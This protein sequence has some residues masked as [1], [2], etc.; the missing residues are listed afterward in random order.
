MLTLAAA[1]AVGMVGAACGTGDD[2]ATVPTARPQAEVTPSPTETAQTPEA[3]TP[4]PTD[5]LAGASTEAAAGPATSN[6]PALLTAVRAARQDGFDRVVFE[7][8]N[9]T[10]GYR[11]EYVDRPITADGSGAAL[12]VDGDA[13]LQ[14]RLANASGVDLSQPDAPATYAG[15]ARIV[16]ATS[17]VAEI[18]RAG[19]FEGMLTW[20]VGVRERAAFRT[21]TLSDPPRLVIDVRAR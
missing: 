4:A 10:P 14:V 6:D 1:A 3:S 2:D 19:D 13:V 15:P 18:V 17:T 8:R 9:A 7:F 5:P 12:S 21:T 20:V 11:I 16:P